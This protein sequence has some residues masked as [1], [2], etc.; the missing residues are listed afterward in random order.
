M[1]A[2]KLE[3]LNSIPR[4]HREEV[5]VPLHRQPT[6]PKYN[7]VK[8]NEILDYVKISQTGSTSYP[9]AEAGGSPISS[10]PKISLDYTARPYL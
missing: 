2:T 7:L 1:L 6:P 3:D 10:S 9:E 4:A 8:R 5:S